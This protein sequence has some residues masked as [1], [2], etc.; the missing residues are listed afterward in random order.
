VTPIN[1]GDAGHREL[2]CSIGRV[3]DVIDIVSALATAIEQ[4]LLHVRIPCGIQIVVEAILIDSDRHRTHVGIFDIT[5]Y[6]FAQVIDVGARAVDRGD[7]E[8]T[9]V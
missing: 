5:A 3:R 6:G 2:E 8:R 4:I 1:T 7:Q 9:T